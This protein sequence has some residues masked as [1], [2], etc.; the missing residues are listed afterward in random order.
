MVCA[1]RRPPTRADLLP[2]GAPLRVTNTMPNGLLNALKNARRH[3]RLMPLGRAIHHPDVI[4]AAPQVIAHLLKARAVQKPRHGD[5][6]HHTSPARLGLLPD[7][8]SEFGMLSHDHWR[9]PHSSW[10]CLPATFRSCWRGTEN[11]AI[12]TLQGS[13]ADLEDMDAA[14][15]SS[16]HRY[17]VRHYHLSP[18]EPMNDAEALELVERLAAEFGFRFE[19]VVVVRHGKPRRTSYDAMMG[20]QGVDTHWHVLAPEVDQITGRV[21]DSRW[22]YLRHE[23]LARETELLLLHQIVKGRWNTCVGA[24]LEARGEHQAASRLRAA[25]IEEGSPAYAAYTARQRRL[26]ER[27][28]SSHG[29]EPLDLPTLVRSLQQCWASYAKRPTCFR[30][31]TSTT[32]TSVTSCRRAH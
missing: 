6:A 16:G 32:G 5:E 17:A 27:R 15:K 23:F 8:A 7:A 2:S 28:H 12:A 3:C 10:Q 30:R 13:E 9:N 25:G 19:A 31:S 11:T 29:G 26:L 14:A 24:E 18:G 4:R 22:M 1:S 20:G 21:L